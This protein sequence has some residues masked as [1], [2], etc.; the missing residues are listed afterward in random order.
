MDTNLGDAEFGRIAH[1]IEAN[2]GIRI[3]PEKRVMIQSRLTKRV[4]ELRFESI[5]AYIRYVLDNDQSNGELSRLVDLVSTHMTSFFREPSHFDLLS[6]HILPELCAGIDF[7]RTK[8]L[9]AWSAAC[10]SGE[11]AYTMAMVLEKFRRDRRRESGRFEYAVL[12]TDLSQGV[13]VSASKAIYPE[14]ALDALPPDYQSGYLMKSRG[15]APARVRVAP[16]I[17][18]RVFFR[19]LNLMQQPYPIGNRIHLIFCRNVLIYFDREH[20]QHVVSGL[21]HC[22]E[23]GGFLVLGHAESILN[24]GNQLRQFAPTVYRKQTGNGG[25]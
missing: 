21:S 13:L 25:N 22:L 7:E 5:D 1:F 8:P 4:R 17:R 18:S 6:N 16:E 23:P 3:P 9:V 10:S 15:D 12:G 2:H 20:Q 24:P 19:Q 14:A 11:E